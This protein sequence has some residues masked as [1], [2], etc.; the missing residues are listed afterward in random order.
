MYVFLL[1]LL[2]CSLL[3]SFLHGLRL[4]EQG[5][6]IV[7]HGKRDVVISALIGIFLL[8]LLITYVSE[9]EPIPPLL[10][11]LAGLII[12]S[13]IE[14]HKANKS[15]TKAY[16]SFSCKLGLILA[17]TFFSALAVSSV[18][19]S[20]GNAKQGRRAAAAKEAGV[21]V[22]SAYSSQWS[23]KMLK[24]LITPR[25]SIPNGNRPKS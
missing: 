5:R 4:G 16:F 22:F 9:D 1:T 19:K 13:Y 6:I 8:M 21:A 23:W 3:F 10:P 24:S 11:L 14:A 17:L 20:M 25:N 2:V 15:H 7:Y 12:Y 18:S